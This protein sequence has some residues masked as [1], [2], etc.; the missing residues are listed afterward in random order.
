L[1]KNK[2]NDKKNDDKKNKS[3]ASSK[4]TLKEVEKRR[5]AAEKHANKEAEKFYAPGSLGRIDQP[6]DI[7]PITGPGGIAMIGTQMPGGQ[8]SIAQAETAYQKSQTLN[9]YVQAALDRMQGGLEGISSQENQ[10]IREAGSREIR[11][12]EKTALRNMRAY[13]GEAGVQGRTAGR[14]AGRVMGE[15]RSLL[16]Q[17]ETDLIAR[18]VAEKGN[19]LAAFGSTANTAYQTQSTAMQNAM[20]SLLGARK[21]VAEYQ[22]GAEKSN[23]IASGENNRNAIEVS[24]ANIDIARGN[25][26][27]RTNTN[28]FNVGQGEKELAGKAGTYY[29]DQA[30]TQ[31]MINQIIPEEL[32]KRAQD[33]ANAGPT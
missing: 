27:A 10:A 15:T 20:N 17:Q 29:G 1:A 8:E 31:A 14:A 26:T 2:N 22:L 19:R 6:T 30:A 18:N 25:Q 23:Q 21:D 12:N 5:E 24:K 13:Q 3:S 4:K 9:P 28:I 33:I 32:A 16:A 11:A 7:G